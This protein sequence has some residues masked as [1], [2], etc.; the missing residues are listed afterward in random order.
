M[1]ELTK[2][3]KNVTLDNGTVNKLHI[4]VSRVDVMTI[5][6]IQ[7]LYSAGTGHTIKTLL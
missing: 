1:W 2:G 4:C 3:F 7:I 5:I 6:A